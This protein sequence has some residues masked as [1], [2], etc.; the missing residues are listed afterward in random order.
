MSQV[1]ASGEV[2][3]FEGEWSANAGRIDKM[4]AD[5][6]LHQE[7]GG[8][9][10]GIA[11]APSSRPEDFTNRRRETGLCN[12]IRK[13]LCFW[14]VASQQHLGVWAIDREL[15]MGLYKRKAW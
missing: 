12:A 8:A 11:A 7:A 14:R 9:A 13:L 15:F 6:V 10:H 1:N 5:I 3:R 4:L 2:G